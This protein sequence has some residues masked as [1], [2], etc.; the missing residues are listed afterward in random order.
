MVGSG[1]GLA[2]SQAFAE[3]YGDRITAMR[4]WGKERP[5][6][7]NSPCCGH[8]PDSLYEISFQGNHV[9]FRMIALSDV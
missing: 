1:L 3:A 8:I 9:S 2:I 5:F 4:G 6:A 7:L